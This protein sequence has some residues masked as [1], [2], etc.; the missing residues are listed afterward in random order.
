MCKATTKESVRERYKMLCVPVYL[1]EAARSV[2]YVLRCCKKRRSG[3]KREGYK[4]SLDPGRSVSSG[5]VP[6]S[7]EQVND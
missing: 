5:Y 4:Q 2:K 3:K 7:V 6:A 1:S